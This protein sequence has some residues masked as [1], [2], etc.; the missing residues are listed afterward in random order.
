MKVVDIANTIN[1]QA[2][3]TII[4]VRPGEKLHEQMISKDDAPYTYEYD[5]YFKILPAINQWSS[6]E[7]RINGGILVDPGFSYSSD[8][9]SE[10]MTKD[11]LNEW[12]KLNNS[13][14]GSY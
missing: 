7:K 9:N 10:W 5:N 8:L 2:K 1:P 14:I 11:E 4:G 12:I 3:H 13:R 6:D